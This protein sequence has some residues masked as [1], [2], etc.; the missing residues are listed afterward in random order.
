MP[1]NYT[2][3]IYFSKFRIGF[4]SLLDV[5]IEIYNQYDPDTLKLLVATLVEITLYPLCGL[6]TVA[7]LDATP[8]KPL[9]KKQRVI[10]LI[11]NVGG[12]P[13]APDPLRGNTLTCSYCSCLATRRFKSINDL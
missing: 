7:V 10:Q 13:E 6:E 12:M 3:N 9:T 8:D 2:L 4:R 1:G 11:Y 5:L